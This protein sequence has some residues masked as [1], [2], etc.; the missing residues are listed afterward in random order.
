MT[1]EQFLLAQQTAYLWA[2]VHI[3]FPAILIGLVLY[4]IGAYIYQTY[5]DN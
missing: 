1:P 2:L 5:Y 4:G 3:A